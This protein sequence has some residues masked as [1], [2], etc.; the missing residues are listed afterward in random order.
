MKNLKSL[1]I[2]IFYYFNHQKCKG[3][4]TV[5]YVL[6]VLIMLIACSGVL[7]I[8]IIAWQYKFELI[9]KITGALSVLFC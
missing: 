7:K 4:A 1:I 8:I 6:F 3:Q 5:E 2:S 9:S